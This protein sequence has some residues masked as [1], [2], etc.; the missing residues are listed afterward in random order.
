MLLERYVIPWFSNF[1]PSI[2]YITS[3]PV[4]SLQVLRGQTHQ[5][6]NLTI[7]STPFYEVRQARKHFSFIEHASTPTR[8]AS[9]RAKHAI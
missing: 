8:K 6:C 4:Y 7:L 3:H 2:E 1:L 9:E 5:E